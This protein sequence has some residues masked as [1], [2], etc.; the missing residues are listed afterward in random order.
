MKLTRQRLLVAL[1]LGSVAAWLVLLGAHWWYREKPNYSLIED[2]LYMGGAVTE[3]P[4]GTRA[5]LN[6]CERQDPYRCDIHLWK[7]IRDAPPAPDLDW[8]REAVEW[9]DTQRR[10]G[11]TTYVHCHAGVSRSGMVV[12]AYLMSRNHW[13]RDEALTFVRTRRPQVQPNPAFM[14]RLGDWE[15]ACRNK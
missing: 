12:T 11:L 10:A 7:Q 1:L 8:L 3:P 6:L 14:E 15:R 9:V 2:D 5:V 13:T 4:P